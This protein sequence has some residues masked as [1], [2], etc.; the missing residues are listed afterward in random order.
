MGEKE[1]GFHIEVP[2]FKSVEAQPP[3]TDVEGGE[4]LSEEAGEEAGREEIAPA[5]PSVCEREETK[6]LY[7]L[8]AGLVSKATQ[9]SLKIIIDSEPMLYE[10]AISLISTLSACS[11]SVKRNV[12]LEDVVTKNKGYLVVSL[13]D[14]PEI[15]EDEIGL[16]VEALRNDDEMRKDMRL[17][18]SR[19]NIIYMLLAPGRPERAPTAALYESRFIERA[20]RA[21]LERLAEKG[22]GEAREKLRYVG[23]VPYSLLLYASAKEVAETT[24]TWTPPPPPNADVL[25]KE[26]RPIDDLVLPDAFKDILK[27]YIE[28]MKEKGRGSIL[29]VGMPRSG[30]KTIAASVAAELGLP[31]YIISIA[32][33]LSRWVG[34]SEQK[35][36]AFF[37][38]M[39][40]RG[41][42][43]VFEDVGTVFKQAG[44]SGTAD[45]ASN[46]RSILYNEMARDDNN[47]V[48][49]FTADE[50]APA[51][52]M[53]SPLL[54]EVKL[55]IPLPNAG[56]R[57]ELA[58]RF[59]SA[60]AGERRQKL[61][62]IA[63][64][65]A[66]KDPE[67][68][69]ENLYVKSFA[70]PTAG[71]TAGELWQVMNL[72]L[73][74]IIKADIE[75]G[76]LFSVTN[77]IANYTKRDYA[78]RLARIKMLSEKA[79]ALGWDQV[80]EAIDEVYKE[81]E[82]KSITERGEKPL[83]E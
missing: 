67:D 40:A 80:S 16:Q 79:K 73:T 3:A 2:E 45:V 75:A 76:R 35:L 69:I 83:S 15:A 71:F 25:H 51:E 74:P 32:N 11:N 30:R 9:M 56:E 6:L 57:V 31:A 49:V 18:F 37:E 66:A 72:I 53:D 29:L 38:G 65:I 27:R 21:V 70:E 61:V 23:R 7:G 1:E 82:K 33:I 17:V 50:R 58:R 8:L 63:R 10:S 19:P 26:A 28:V 14:S 34:E 68:H 52:L 78:A 5:G 41:G 64:S 62:E 36:R 54:G 42:L 39:R 20:V 48:M 81:L 44:G 47:F 46:L 24:R 4:R 12:P 55:V 43:A 60:I 59:F 22:D 77:E 13:F